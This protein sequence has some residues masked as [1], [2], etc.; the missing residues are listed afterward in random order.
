MQ[1]RCPYCGDR[2]PEITDG[3]HRCTTPTCRVTHYL[4]TLTLPD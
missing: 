1:P 3:T 2:G 4:S